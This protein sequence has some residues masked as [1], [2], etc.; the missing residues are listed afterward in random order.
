M[1][2]IT[3]RDSLKIAG[4]LAASLALPGLASAERFPAARDDLY[5]LAVGDWGQPA[6]Q[7]QKQVAAAMAA[8]ADER[9]QRFV[10]SL[11]DNFYRDGVT[12][13]DD[14][15]WRTSFEDIYDA[16]SLQCRWHPILGN[17]DRRGDAM[18]QVAYSQKSARWTMPAPFYWLSEP[19]SDSS[20]VDFF[21]LDTTVIVNDHSG[22]H[23][24]MSGNSGDEQL[25][26]LDQALAASRARW[27]IVIGHHP[28]LSSGPHGSTS[29]LVSQVKPLLERHGAAIYVCGHDHNMQHVVSDNIHYIV[30]GTGSDTVDFHAI[31]PG[32]VFTRRAL[33]FLGF[34]VTPARIDVRFIDDNGVVLHTVGL[35]A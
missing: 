14:P 9:A 7:G 22:L 34:T 24:L 10:V 31:I 3:R 19:L 18:A 32:S 27:K 5:F 4:S 30:C 8:T 29:A 20:T 11:G 6:A 1:S 23:Y 28:I 12:G 25:S 15:R 2:D 21:F 26:W 13:V 16:P 35:V 17:H 33:G